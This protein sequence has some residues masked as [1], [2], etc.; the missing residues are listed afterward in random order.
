MAITEKGGTIHSA[1]DE[2]K[3]IAFSFKRITN[4]KFETAMAFLED[5]AKDDS[6]SRL[7]KLQKR[8]EAFN[9]LVE[10][11][12]AVLEEGTRKDVQEILTA[13]IRFN[14]GELDEKK[15]E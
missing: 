9:M 8:D 5:S 10:N 7:E 11:G 15:S 3:Q 13:A 12:P 4:R 14:N 6:L 2:G 1:E